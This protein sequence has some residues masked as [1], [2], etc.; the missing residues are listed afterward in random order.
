MP[1]AAAAAA[2]AALLGYGA[3][4]HADRAARRSTRRRPFAVGLVQANIGIHEKGN[5]ALFDINLDNYRELSAPAA[6]ARST[7]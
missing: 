4:A 7:C 6:V 5:V 1:L 2:A 3:L